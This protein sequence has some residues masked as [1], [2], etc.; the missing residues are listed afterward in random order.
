MKTRA[1]AKG[2]SAHLAADI[3][4][5]SQSATAAPGP[6]LLLAA[7]QLDSFFNHRLP[8]AKAAQTEGWDVHV[9]IN[10]ADQAREMD[11]NGFTFHPWPLARSF[12]S[13]ARE[14]DT[15][16]SLNRLVRALKPDIVHA[17]TLKPA[18]YA[19]LISR[20]QK[21]ATVMSV[22]GVGSFFLGQGA[23][24]QA[25]RVALTMALRV[26]L[27]S[28]RQMAI[29]Q[30]PDDQALVT[31]RFGV[32]A[33]RTRL[34]PG[35]GVDLVQF[36]PTQTPAP[37][38]VQIVLAA[39]MLADKGVREFVDAARRL[40]GEGLNARF[41]LAGGLDPANRSAITE[42][43]LNS[44]QAEGSVSW[45][46]QVEDMAALYRDSHIACLPSYRE[47]LPKALLEAAA[48][49][50]PCVTTD[51]PGCRDAIIAGETGLLAP[52]RD[53]N[54]LADALRRL[55]TDAAL[56]KKMGTAGRAFISKGHSNEAIASAVL[57]T[58]AL[59]GARA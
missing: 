22:T 14:L 27:G 35:S 24:E 12:A 48:C 40:L 47:G 42:T 20:W 59:L 34:I 19:A 28:K 30:N 49:G 55:I 7:N 41:V 56:R 36:S 6:R 4:A 52:V 11:T 3:A 50:L 18:L 23:K 29:V 8:I 33:A 54:G 9:A 39:R 26:A 38:P 45:L 51:V 25:I 17:F 46:G 53:A 13:P 5:P 16:T 32:P 1:S 10:E 2:D 43:E 15:L 57:E 21:Q 58:Y 44:W 31:T 37:P